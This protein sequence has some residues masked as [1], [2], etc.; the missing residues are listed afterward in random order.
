MRESI[1]NSLIFNWVMIF[2]GVIIALLI[3]SM[4][5][6]KAYKIKSKIIS[7]V[8]MYQGYTAEARTDIDTFLQN[9]GYRFNTSGSRCEDIEGFTLLTDNSNYYRYCVYQTT[10][11]KGSYYKVIAYMY[12]DIPFIEG[13]MEFPVSGE[14]KVIYDLNSL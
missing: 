7:T 10:T 9:V 11:L 2:V 5:Y 13:I 8:E 1:S 3:A 12:F 4:S 14:S 6:S